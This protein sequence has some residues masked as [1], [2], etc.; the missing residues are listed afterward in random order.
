MSI[1][2]PALKAMHPSLPVSPEPLE[3]GLLSPHN[4]FDRL[5]FSGT[6]YQAHQALLHE[7]G[8]N[9]RHLGPQHRPH[10]RLD[11]IL[12]RPPPAPTLD[13][14]NLGGLDAVVGLVA[15]PL[16]KSFAQRSPLPFLHVTD[17]TP[18]FLRDTY[19]WKIP[20]QADRNEAFVTARAALSVYSSSAMATRARREFGLP[21]ARTQTVPFGIN[22]D[23]L[24]DNCPRKPALSHVNLLFVGVEWARKGGDIA[25]AALDRLIASGQSASLTLVGRVPAA[26][27]SHPNVHVVGFLN[28]NRPRDRAKLTRLYR[29]AHVMMLPTRG[30]CTPM[31]IAEAM[32]HGTPVLAT[33][34]G[35]TAELI[36]A[37]GAGN[38]LPLAAT[39]Q[40]WAQAVRKITSSDAQYALMSDAAFD[41]AHNKYTWA[42]WARGINLCLQS[43]VHA[44]RRN[45]AFKP[46]SVGKPETI[47]CAQ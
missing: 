11:R 40:D 9:I 35:G 30:D 21:R 1:P 43:I 46:Q 44:H 26:L 38:V 22:L 25:V 45:A 13:G 29:Q 2:L 33:D 41:R 5:S 8:L 36:G 12:R 20:Q 28:K 42:A 4:V 31:V 7:A 17:A 3:I 34:T 6:A 14:V 19:G 27:T 24:P 23:T 16:L 37:S 32:A 18:G 15:T 39:A 47:A 10:F